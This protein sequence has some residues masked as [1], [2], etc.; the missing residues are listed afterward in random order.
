MCVVVV[1]TIFIVDNGFKELC[2]T[3]SKVNSDLDYCQFWHSSVPHK[4]WSA[5][6]AVEH[7]GK[8]DEPQEL[9][10]SYCGIGESTVES[11]RVAQVSLCS[12]KYCHLL[13]L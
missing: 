7:P 9:F 5:L 13:V 2:L 11:Y 10:H 8:F 6:L 4:V 1:Y 12:I 3:W